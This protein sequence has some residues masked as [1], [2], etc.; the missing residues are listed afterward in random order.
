M[1]ISSKD[2]KFKKQ[3]AIMTIQPSATSWEHY[4]GHE[5][6]QETKALDMLLCSINPYRKELRDIDD[7]AEKMKDYREE[8]SS[9]L[10]R[11][12]HLFK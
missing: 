12:R 10:Y 11:V 3:V 2:L 1:K 9:L 7:A 6:E 4:E 8:L 5:S